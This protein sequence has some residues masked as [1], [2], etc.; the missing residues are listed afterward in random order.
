[1]LRLR[2]H[3]DV[4]DVPLA[5]SAVDGAQLQKTLHAL[6]R[7]FHPDS[8]ANKSHE[9]VARCEAIASE[10]N[11]AYRVLRDDY[12]RCRYVA[13]CVALFGSPEGRAVLSAADAKGAVLTDSAEVKLGE[14]V[15]AAFLERMMAIHEEI[16][17]ALDDAEDGDGDSK[18]G[19]LGEKRWAELLATVDAVADESRAA[20]TRCLDEH[21]HEFWAA[22]VIGFSC[23]MVDGGPSIGAAAQDAQREFTRALQRWTYARNLQQKLRD[24]K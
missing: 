18:L 5:A 13:Y 22:R 21:G 4:L 2:T 15:D 24:L 1:L 7:R 11:A 20:C 16:D 19:G 3:F 17:D 23:D 10:V 6:Q 8:L 14:Q 12:D 9:E